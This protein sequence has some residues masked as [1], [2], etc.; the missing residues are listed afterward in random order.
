MYRLLVS[1]SVYFT[2]ILVDKFDKLIYSFSLAVVC[3]LSALK[4]CTRLLGGKG[5]AKSSVL[6]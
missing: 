2:N 3:P 4:G 1:Q 6:I 5:K